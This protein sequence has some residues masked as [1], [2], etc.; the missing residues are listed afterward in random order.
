MT[1]MTISNR[2]VPSLAIGLQTQNVSQLVIHY[3]QAPTLSILYFCNFL[4]HNFFYSP[5]E[6][7]LKRRHGTVIITLHYPTLD[8]PAADIHPASSFPVPYS[9]V[10]AENPSHE[11]ASSAS[12]GAAAASKPALGSANARD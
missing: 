9:G 2:Q 3:P 7:T 5:R 12:S 6:P 1:N 11:S 8:S 10:V 4:I